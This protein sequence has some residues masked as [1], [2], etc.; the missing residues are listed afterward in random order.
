M[1]SKTK[2]VIP[3]ATVDFLSQVDAKAEEIFAQRKLKDPNYNGGVIIEHRMVDCVDHN[4]HPVDWNF[5]GP[6][7]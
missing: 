7:V 1:Y 3:D 6:T 4:N 2:T 5:P